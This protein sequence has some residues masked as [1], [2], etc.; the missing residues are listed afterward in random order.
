MVKPVTSEFGSMD[1]VLRFTNWTSQVNNLFFL[2]SFYV[3]TVVVLKIKKIAYICFI[4][5]N[6]TYLINNKHNTSQLYTTQLHNK[7]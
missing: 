2:S 1:W 6:I 7:S 5:A 3:F 4:R